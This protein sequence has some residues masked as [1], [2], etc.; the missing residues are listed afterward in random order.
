MADKKPKDFTAV[1]T[2]QLLLLSGDTEFYFQ[3]DAGEAIPADDYKG[4]FTQLLELLKDLGV[5]VAALPGEYVSDAAATTA[6]GS[7]GDYYRLAPGNIYGWP[8]DG[9]ILKRIQS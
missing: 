3:V 2:A 9:G 6:G 7:V 1:S 8:S 4:T 5:I